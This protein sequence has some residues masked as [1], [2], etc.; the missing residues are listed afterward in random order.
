MISDE[1]M[2]I[3]RILTPEWMA[4]DNHLY[5]E[6]PVFRELFCLGL[7]QSKWMGGKMHINL[8]SSA[9]QFVPNMFN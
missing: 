1:A 6:M 3:L 9:S 8:T 4:V 2:E 5:L 7:V